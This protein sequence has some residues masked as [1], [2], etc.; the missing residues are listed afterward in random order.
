MTKGGDHIKTIL[1]HKTTGQLGTLEY[2]MFGGSVHTI[3]EDGILQKTLGN[4]LDNILKEWDIVDLPVGYE[5][6]EYGG[7]RKMN[8]ED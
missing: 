6:G 4:R 3:G 8:N 1:Q 2:S 5:L 7:V